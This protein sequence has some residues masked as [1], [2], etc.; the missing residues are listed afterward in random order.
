MGGLRI[1]QKNAK[2]HAVRSRRIATA[3]ISLGF[4]GLSV[5]SPEIIPK[6]LKPSTTRMRIG[7]F[8]GF[9]LAWRIDAS[10]M[11]ELGFSR[12]PQPTTSAPIKSSCS[13]LNNL[14]LSQTIASSKFSGV[15]PQG[16]LKYLTS[17]MFIQKVL[18][19][20]NTI[21]QQQ[22]YHLKGLC[23]TVR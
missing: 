3:K 15:I 2:K 13:H 7:P 4:R 18:N 11:I 9:V 16:L 17:L 8:S 14:G 19:N 10:E 1:N 5:E 6:V 23:T 21:G 22:I 20:S 12:A